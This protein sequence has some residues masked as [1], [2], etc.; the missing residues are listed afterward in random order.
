MGKKLG[1][2]LER[3]KRKIERQR[4]DLQSS[5]DKAAELGATIQKAIRLHGKA[6]PQP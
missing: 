1:R 2:E 5:K 3:L 4:K 6:P